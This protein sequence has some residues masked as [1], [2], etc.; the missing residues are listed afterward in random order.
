MRANEYK[1]QVIYISNHK[2]SPCL[3]PN[4]KHLV[5]HYHSLVL[6]QRQIEERLLPR[7]RRP[8]WLVV[9]RCWLASVAG[10]FLFA[11][12]EVVGGSLSGGFHRQ[13]LCLGQLEILDGL[14]TALDEGGGSFLLD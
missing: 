5:R 13:F 4:F 9:V 8:R 2:T 6:L 3:S 12:L 7:P 10:R 14:G 1:S 11:A